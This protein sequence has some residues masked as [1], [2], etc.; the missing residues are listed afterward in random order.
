MGPKGH[1]MNLAKL[2]KAWSLIASI[3][4]RILN[5]VATLLG[6]GGRVS[7][8]W[9][10]L[11]IVR[12]DRISIGSNFSAGRSLWLESV[13]G[14]GRLIIGDDVNISDWVHIGCANRIE[15]KDGVLIGSKVLIT[16]HS[17]GRVDA[18]G[19]DEIE[20]RPNMRTVHSKG[21]VSIGRSAWIG[22]GVC[23]LANVNIGDDSIVG[24]NSVVL[25]DIPSGTIWAGT[26]AKQIWP[27]TAT[28]PS[29]GSR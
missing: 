10:D 23:V 19:I 3:R 5:G 12:P 25:T 22:D 8:D 14:Q 11:K 9:H 13:E 7:V 18:R 26:P 17:H 15:I 21:P 1:G 20:I 2:L 16:D 29:N 6:C 27:P 4:N 24:A 28:P